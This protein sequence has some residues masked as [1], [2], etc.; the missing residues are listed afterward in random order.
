MNDLPAVFDAKAFFRALEAT[1]SARQMKWK[2]VS[3]QTGVSTST[4]S[5]M[6]QGRGPDA[7]G[8]AV[9]SAWSGLNPGD[10]TSMAAPK[11]STEPLA[12]LSSL[13]RQDPRLSA[14]AAATLED[15]LKV[16]Y[17]RLAQ[18]DTGK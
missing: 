4:L 7:G 17:S 15:V 18:K 16:T 6:A 8:L 12:M 11:P 14:E 1:A 2:D 10:F 9:L 5:R 13:L 3:Q